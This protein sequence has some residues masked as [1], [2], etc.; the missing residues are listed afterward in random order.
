MSTREPQDSPLDQPWIVFP[1][2]IGATIVAVWAPIYLAKLLFAGH[3][4]L[5][6]AGFVGWLVGVALTVICLK[7]R[8]YVLAF[9][10]MLLLLLGVGLLV[11]QALPAP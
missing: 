6:L 8:M 4:V 7:E 10:P 11:H 1:E 2:I 3:V 9:W 5:S